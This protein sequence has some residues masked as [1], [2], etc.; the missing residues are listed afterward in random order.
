[1]QAAQLLVQVD[2]A[3]GQAGQAAIAAE[4]LGRHLHRAAQRVGEGHE[5][6]R[7]RAGLGQAVELLFGA[8]DLIAGAAVGGGGPDGDLAA[9]ADQ[10][11]A[12]GQVVDQP[13]I[14]GGVGPWRGAV[15]Q[16]GQIAQPAQLIEGGVLAEPLHHH[17]RLGQLALLDVLFDGREQ[18]GV[19]RLIEVARLQLVAQP[20][21]HAVVEQQRAQQGLLGFQI[22]RRVSDPRVV[23]P[24][25]VGQGA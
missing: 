8:L 21:E 17:D 6:G 13:A 10:V 24:S 18:P 12:Q 15:H 7:D 25:I 22:V 9:D 3:G 4:G 11:A 23:G 19:E 2:Q 5:P 14:F 1:M 16:I 20:L